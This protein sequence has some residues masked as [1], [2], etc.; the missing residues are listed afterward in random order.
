[1]P[2]PSR[3]EPETD[4][5]DEGLSQDGHMI[6]IAVYGVL[7]VAGFAFGVVTGYEAPKPPVVVVKKDKPDPPVETPKPTPKVNPET[8]GPKKIDPPETKP[9]PKPE[10]KKIDTPPEPKKIDP[11][12][13][14]KKEV[15]PQLVFKDVLPVLRKHCTECHGAGKAQ[16]GVDVTTVAMILKS[17]SK[18]PM[19]VAGK[20]ELSRLYTTITDG[21]MPKDN[22]SRL[23]DAELK[24]LRDWILGGAKE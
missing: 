4:H 14:P 10:P 3:L 22:K 8:P 7:V 17:R 5:E 16:A 15:V 19:L 20:P 1:M 9:E 12:T 11:P 6:G 21:D 24:T 2:K 23:T 18:E 13:E